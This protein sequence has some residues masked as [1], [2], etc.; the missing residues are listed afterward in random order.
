MIE[1]HVTFEVLPDKTDEFE[2]FFS[3]HYRPAMSRMPGFVKVELLR[4]QNAP[5]RYQMVIRF[6]TADDAAGWRASPEHQGLSPQ[7]KTLYSG[8]ELKVYDVLG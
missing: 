3:E 6:Q 1:R 7:I 4:E 8:S 5:L 2:K